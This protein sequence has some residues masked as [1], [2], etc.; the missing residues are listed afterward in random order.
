MGHV[1]DSI[2]KV[3]QNGSK[4]MEA[5]IAD[6]KMENKRLRSLLHDIRREITIAAEEL[7]LGLL[8]LGCKIN[9]ELLLKLKGVPDGIN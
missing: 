4:R 1:Q 3:L 8:E 9:K 6:L 5:E 2:M 7:P